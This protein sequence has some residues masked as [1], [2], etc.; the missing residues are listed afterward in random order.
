MIKRQPQPKSPINKFDFDYIKHY[1][2]VSANKEGLSMERRADFL[3]RG[4]STLYR[5]R[6]AKS[7]QEYQYRV[8]RNHQ[9]SIENIEVTRQ[10]SRIALLI[11]TLAYIMALVGMGYL[12]T[13]LGG[14]VR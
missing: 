9:R 6:K 4:L 5:I 12:F 13:K 2:N 8:R 1:L 14:I 7:F 3:G 11:I 10:H